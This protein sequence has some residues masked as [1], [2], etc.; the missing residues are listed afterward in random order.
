MSI[1]DLAKQILSD[2]W[3]YGRLVLIIIGVMAAWGFIISRSEDDRENTQAS[4]ILIALA[5]VGVFILFSFL[6]L[7]AGNIVALMHIKP[8][9]GMFT[10]GVAL[11]LIVVS[12]VTIYQ[13]FAVNRAE[14]SFSIT[15]DDEQLPKTTLTN[16]IKLSWSVVVLLFLASV[17]WL[18]HLAAG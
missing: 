4:L 17:I 16:T 14:K 6:N 1:S 2:M 11:S 12:G 13:Y 8:A 9:W 5:T 7:Q 18:R 15:A 10:S 3:A